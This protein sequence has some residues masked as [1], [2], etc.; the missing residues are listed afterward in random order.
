METVRKLRIPALLILLGGIAAFSCGKDSQA[1]RP[2][3]GTKGAAVMDM[4]KDLFGSLPDGTAVEAFTLSNGSGIEARIMTYGA[5]LI[6]LRL[7]DRNGDFEDVALGFE[8]L[9]G[10]LGENPYFGCT[11]GRYANRIGRAKFSL[12]GVEYTLARNDG[13]NHL[14]GGLKGFD[15]VVWAAEPFTE[16]DAVGVRFTYLSADMEEGYPGNLSCAVTYRLTGEDELRI[17]YE[18][19][20]DKATP[21]NLTNHTYW[22]LAGQGKGDIL[23][24]VLQIEADKYTPVDA[25]LIPTGE[26]SDVPGTPLDFTTPHPI[27]E[28][29]A[30]IEGGYDH[31][32]V[33]RRAG[34]SPG[35]AALVYEPESGRVLEILTDQPGIQFYSGNFLDGTIKGKGESLYGKH[36]GFCLETQHF[37]DSP[38][39]PGFPPTIL[40]PGKT[41]RTA[42]VHRFFT[43]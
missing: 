41:Y 13:E 35:L 29:I 26:I 24:H 22:N 18:A 8:T 2:A 36:A 38:N 20:T 10:Y 1:L 21:V 19:A 5:T 34:G 6:S 15:K 39:K 37:P 9:G 40:E 31:N 43:R 7:P 30:R 4:K 33:L 12:G 16:T 14:H 23:G 32:F 11:V 17:D 28:R 25:G 27:G 42:T 3:R